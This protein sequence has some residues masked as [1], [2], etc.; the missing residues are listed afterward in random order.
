MQ[1]D[2]EIKNVFLRICKV[3]FYNY[4][5]KMSQQKQRLVVFI[6]L[7]LVFNGKL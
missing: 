3:Y 1:V 2:W 7:F 4:S 5:Y 6:G